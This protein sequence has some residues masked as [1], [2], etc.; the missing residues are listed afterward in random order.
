[1]DQRAQLHQWPD[2]T[3]PTSGQHNLSSKHSCTQPRRVVSLPSTKENHVFA[4]RPD[5]TKPGAPDPFFLDQ[6]YLPPQHDMYYRPFTRSTSPS[7]EADYFQYWRRGAIEGRSPYPLS[8]GYTFPTR[9]ESPFDFDYDHLNPSSPP[10]DQSQWDLT[11]Q[12]SQSLPA[13]QANSSRRE[14]TPQPSGLLTRQPSVSESISNQSPVTPNSHTTAH[15]GNTIPRSREL[16]RTPP[17]ENCSS[18][19]E[20]RVPVT[21]Q[22]LHK[23]YISPYPR[24][25]FT[26]ESRNGASDTDFWNLSSGNRAAQDNI[27]GTRSHAAK[28]PGVSSPSCSC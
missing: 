13:Q 6:S 2:K 15:S 21:T 9:Q 10:F 24:P 18:E 4:T 28:S 3:T 22:S 14:C 11:F 7:A 12:S 23:P 20:H 5:I 19:I 8:P 26:Q 16:A 1:M 17:T 25:K 27:G